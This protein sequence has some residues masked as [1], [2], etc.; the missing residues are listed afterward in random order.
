[1]DVTYQYQKLGF[2]YF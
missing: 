2:L 1:L